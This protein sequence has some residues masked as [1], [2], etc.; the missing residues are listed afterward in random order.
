MLLQGQLLSETEL[1]RELQA[2]LN[3]SITWQQ[4]DQRKVI[5]SML[6]HIGTVDSELRDG[7][8]YGT[9]YTMI[10]EKNLLDHAI[11]ND[12]FDYC[13]TNLLCKGIG[14]NH[15]DSVFTRTF[16]SLLIALILTR[17]N[18]DDFLEAYK[19]EEL[20]NKVMAYL[21]AEKD[22]RGYVPGKGWAHSVAHVSDLVDEL[23]QN[24]KFN[25]ASYIAILRPLLNMLLQTD[26]AFIH[27]EDERLLAPL[28]T[29]L[30]RGLPQQEVITLLNETM[31][32]LSAQKEQQDVQHY[33]ILRF[34]WKTLLKS[35]YILTADRP[36]YKA[37]HQS[38]KDC[39]NI[40][41]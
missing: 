4:A 34:N 20:T 24:A 33:R 41:K 2:F 38:I 5:H 16:T 13:L 11:L 28:F 40:D 25:K 37:L 21:D 1:K 30:E 3:D 14:E 9:F 23:V 27:D 10:L 39:L 29:M 15:T 18:E 8:I 22:V 19:I 36:Q 6:V 7:L 32:T 17:D 12:T 26:Y 31:A 35:F